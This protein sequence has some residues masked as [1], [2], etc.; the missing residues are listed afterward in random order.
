MKKSQTVVRNKIFKDHNFYESKQSSRPMSTME[1]EQFQHQKG[2]YEFQS[3]KVPIFAEYKH[4]SSW[5]P[6]NRKYER[7]DKPYK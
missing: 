3:K 4:A 5:N 7:I 2:G 1:Y 6:L